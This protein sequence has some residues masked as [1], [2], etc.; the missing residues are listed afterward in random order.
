[1]LKYMYKKYSSLMLTPVCMFGVCTP[2]LKHIFIRAVLQGVFFPAG[3]SGNLTDRKVED[4]R[5]KLE[6]HRKTMQ[7]KGREQRV[8]VKHVLCIQIAEI[9]FFL[10]SQ[11]FLIFTNL[12][13]Q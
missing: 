13:C 10:I 3:F 1:M 12:N 9:P 5:G 4:F 2:F 8:G 11:E 6:E 7:T